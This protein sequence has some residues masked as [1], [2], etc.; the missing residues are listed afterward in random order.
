MRAQLV[1]DK[2]S[3]LVP[4]SRCCAVLVLAGATGL[5]GVGTVVAV[6]A[7]TAGVAGGTPA[8]R[9]GSRSLRERGVRSTTKVK[10]VFRLFRLV[11]LFVQMFK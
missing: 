1:R 8:H 9:P 7:A 3:E 4:V 5:G 11:L 6:A 10:F 2:A